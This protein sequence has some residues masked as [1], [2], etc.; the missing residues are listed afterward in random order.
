MSAEIKQDG[1]CY[2]KKGKLMTLCVKDTSCALNIVDKADAKNIQSLCIPTAKC[3][4]DGTYVPAGGDAKVKGK[5]F[6]ISAAKTKCV[7]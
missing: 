5:T 7:A 6:A 4:K 2:D 3:G 1:S